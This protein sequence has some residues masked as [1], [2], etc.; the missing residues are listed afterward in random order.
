VIARRFAATGHQRL[1]SWAE[2]KRSEESGHDELALRDLVELGYRARDLVSAF[3]PPRA[4]A[5]VALFERLA[6]ADDPVGCVGYAHALER[7]A[8]LRG[9]AEVQ[10]IEQNLPA[11]VHAT[12]CLRVHSSLG[13]DAGHV[14]TNVATTAALNAD[15]RRAIVQACHLTARIYFDPA[16]N[17]DFH[18]AGLEAKVQAFRGHARASPH[19]LTTTRSPSAHRNPNSIS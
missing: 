10:A 3:V 1:A 5:W 2:R 14:Q 17:D 4:A 18:A 7:L 15:E 16:L 19:S 12:R 6:E 13:S 11:G 8:L 9:P